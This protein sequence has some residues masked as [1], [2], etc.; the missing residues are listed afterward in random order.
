MNPSHSM[1][2][3][4]AMHCCRQT[5]ENESALAW[6]LTSRRYMKRDNMHTSYPMPRPSSTRGTRRGRCERYGNGTRSC[7][8]SRRRSVS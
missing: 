1:M 7:A 3:L 5:A 6:R 2:L 4:P 8:S